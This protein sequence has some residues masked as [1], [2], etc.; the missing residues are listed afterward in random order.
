MK[1]EAMTE[2]RFVR[3]RNRFIA[4]VMINGMTEAVHVRNT[5]RLRE[6]FITDARVLL[7]PASNPERKTRYSLV[8][9]EKNGQWVNVDSTAPNQIVEEMVRAG[10]LFSDITYMKREKTFGKSR[11]DLYV[12]HGGRKHYIEV[13]GVTLEVDGAARFPDAPTERGIKH[14]HEL[15]EARRQGY[16]AS[17]IFIIQ[18]KGIKVFEPNRATHPAFAEALLEA[19]GAGVEILAFDCMVTENSLEGDLPVPVRLE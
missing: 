18:M 10:R 6:L 12:E 1:Y 15:M 9:V 13:K 16:L 5:G 14:I 8:C 17:I 3:R 19:A 4:E 7:E 11:F 2:G